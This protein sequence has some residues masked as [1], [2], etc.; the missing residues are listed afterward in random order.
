[1]LRIAGTAW[2]RGQESELVWD[3]LEEESVTQLLHDDTD[4][5]KDEERGGGQ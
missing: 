3:E 1:M 5:D 4:E 2:E